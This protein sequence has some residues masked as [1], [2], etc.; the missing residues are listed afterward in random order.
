MA[1]QFNP[2]AFLGRLGKYNPNSVK[3]V[4]KFG[5]SVGLNQANTGM[6]YLNAGQKALKGDIGG[7][8]TTGADTYLGAAIPA[9]GALKTFN[10]LTGGGIN[11]NRMMN[12]KKPVYD[13]A[14]LARKAM[15][16]GEIES[17]RNL[18]SE[19]IRG[20]TERRQAI[21]PM[22]DKVQSDILD[23]LTQGL[24]SR[25]LAPI[26]GAGEARNRQIGAA[27]QA[28]MQ[29][30]LASRGVSGGVQAGVEQANLASQNERS[31]ALNNAI[32]QQQIQQRPEMLNMASNLLAQR[33]A[34]ALSEMQY[35][36]GLNLQ[37]SQMANQQALQ[38]RQLRMQEDAASRARRQQEM[39]SVG[40][41]MA[42]LSPELQRLKTR[43][44]KP[45]TSDFMPTDTPT[46]EQIASEILADEKAQYDAL[47]NNAPVVG[48]SGNF[49][50]DLRDA[51]ELERSIGE[52]SA[53]LGDAFNVQN[54]LRGTFGLAQPENVAGEMMR[55]TDVGTID[56]I[57]ASRAKRIMKDVGNGL[58]IMAYK[59]QATGQYFKQYVR[60]N[61][62]LLG[63]SIS[64]N[65]VLTKSE[66]RQQRGV[67][68]LGFASAFY[69]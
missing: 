6:G 43:D 2:F 27:S 24:S 31:A 61:P 59:D 37:A 48:R 57:E 30:Q 49:F 56:E 33:D 19:Q 15:M 64:G 69:G 26:Y 51:S 18:A 4:N 47:L 9:Y 5:S 17:Q 12:P 20:A 39:E 11:F 41:L 23:M 13:E 44:K 25:Q 54:V 32:T 42:L 40:Q 50:Q 45:G 67:S 66:Q 55:V 65:P 63:E 8:L 60:S 36:Q 58:A 62:A 3:G 22:Q 1:Q 52:G 21:R 38:E 14:D 34:Q 53:P 68:P 7:A 46:S 35:G 29:Q 10:Q 16:T 28:A